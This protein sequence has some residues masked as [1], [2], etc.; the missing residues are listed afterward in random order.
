LTKYGNVGLYYI[1]ALFE[2]KF[3]WFTRLGPCPIPWCFSRIKTETEEA[4]FIKVN[5]RKNKKKTNED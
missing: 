3:V 5:D 4:L 1:K 2:D